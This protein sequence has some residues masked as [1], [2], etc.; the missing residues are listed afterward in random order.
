MSAYISISVKVEIT[1][2]PKAMRVPKIDSEG[3]I[4]TA[5]TKLKAISKVPIKD[6]IMAKINGNAY[7]IHWFLSKGLC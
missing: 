2:L 6:N 3:W 5:L 4:T 1:I 7:D